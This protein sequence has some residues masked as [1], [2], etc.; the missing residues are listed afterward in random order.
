MKDQFYNIN[1]L[2]TDPPF[3]GKIR[4]EI[5][6]LSRDNENNLE[7]YSLANEYLIFFFKLRDQQ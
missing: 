4:F 5:F 2:K 1:K 7:N 3:V 6:L